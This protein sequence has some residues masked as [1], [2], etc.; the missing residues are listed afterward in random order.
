[1]HTILVVEDDAE[2]RELVAEV[3]VAD[4]YDVV[5]AANGQEAL[6]YLQTGSPKPCVIL[7]DL[8]MP[9]LSGPEL[10]EIMAEDHNLA[11][12]PVVV[13]SAMAGRGTAPGVRRFLKKPVSSAVLRRVVAEYCQDPPGSAGC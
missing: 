9:V 13:V 5:K 3:L 10:I 1:M 6:D 2:I 7:L 8:M 4:G 11:A 12:L